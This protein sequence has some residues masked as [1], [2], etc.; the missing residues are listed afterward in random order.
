MSNKK[1]TNLKKNVAS[2]SKTNFIS[3]IISR[4]APEKVWPLDKIESLFQFY[5][6][7]NYKK[8]IR[9]QKTVESLQIAEK[10]RVFFSR[11]IWPRKRRRNFFVYDITMSDLCPFSGW[12]KL[13]GLCSQRLLDL[14]GLFFLWFSHLRS[15]SAQFSSR[16]NYNKQFSVCWLYRRLDWLN[17]SKEQG[18]NFWKKKEKREKFWRV[19]SALFEEPGG[20]REK[21]ETNSILEKFV[22]LV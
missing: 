4:H 2:G 11:R 22:N 12:K 17:S 9:E 16:E 15:G 3:P 13:V 14:K 20:R 7:N 19:T 21:K 18:R 10:I 5:D 8:M 6:R 1:H